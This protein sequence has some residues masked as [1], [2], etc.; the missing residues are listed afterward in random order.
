MLAVFWTQLL[1]R[2]SQQRRLRAEHLEMMEPGI[3]PSMSGGGDT[4]SDQHWGSMGSCWLLEGI[5]FPVG[6]AESG[7]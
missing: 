6:M 5:H 3:N 4:E 7:Y 2:H 1:H